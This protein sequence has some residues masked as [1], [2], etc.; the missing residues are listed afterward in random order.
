MRIIK[1]IFFNSLKWSLFL[2]LLIYFCWL[3]NHLVAYYLV[4]PFSVIC[5]WKNIILRKI[6][7]FRTVFPVFFSEEL[8]LWYFSC[9]YL[10]LCFSEGYSIL[11]ISIGFFGILYLI[12]RWFIIDYTELD[13]R[14]LS[15]LSFIILLIYN[16]IGLYLLPITI[17]LFLIVN[18]FIFSVIWVFILFAGSQD[19]IGLIQVIAAIYARI[20]FWFAQ[21]WS[22][23]ALEFI[24]I[25]GNSRVLLLGVPISTNITSENESLSNPFKSLIKYFWGFQ[26]SLWDKTAIQKPD[27]KNICSLTE[28]YKDLIGP[29]TL[30]YQFPIKTS[31]YIFF[32]AH[33]INTPGHSANFRDSRAILIYPKW[34]KLTITFLD[35][36]RKTGITYIAASEKAYKYSHN[37]LDISKHLDRPIWRFQYG[38]THI[39]KQFV[40]INSDFAN[41]SKTSQALIATDFSVMQKYAKLKLAHLNHLLTGLEREYPQNTNWTAF[42]KHYNVLNWLYLENIVKTPELKPENQVKIAYYWERAYNENIQSIDIYLTAE[43]ISEGKPIDF[44]KINPNKLIVAIK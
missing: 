23:L 22:I 35:A 16:C 12:R 17:P 33:I 4:I 26:L 42:R 32:K 6:K 31:D 8:I 18:I 9:S 36:D 2:I 43:A 44:K 39:E 21:G 3:N 34:E 13:F 28:K 25:V 10:I 24:E 14:I 19:N 37:I 11:S 41:Y 1:N 30:K 7:E 5:L 20:P 27:I 29:G 15:I 40:K 38:I